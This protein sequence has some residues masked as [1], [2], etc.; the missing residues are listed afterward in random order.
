MFP[1]ARALFPLSSTTHLCA[2]GDRAATTIRLMAAVA[3]LGLTS[4]LT[5]Y[6]AAQSDAA[7]TPAASV[8]PLIGTGKGPGGGINLFPGPSLPFGMVQL[9]PDTEDNGY[10]YHYDQLTIHGFSMT[11]MS[12]PG[13]SNEGDVFFTATTGPVKTQVSDFQSP[14]SHSDEAASPGYYRVRLARW[15][16]NAELSA[17]DRTGIARFT[18][19]A[20]KPANILVPI[21]HTLNHTMAAEVR[22]VGDRQI[23]GYVE[24]QAFCG[25]KQTYKVYFD[26][27]FS[28][29]FGSYGTWSGAPY[30]GPGTVTASS[31]AAKQ[32]THNAWIG[33]YASWPAAQHTQT[34]TARVGISYVDLAGAENNLKA[35]SGGK[36]FSTIRHNAEGAWNKALRVIDVS[37]G[38]AEERTVFY[39]AL[40]HSLMMPSIFSDAD[41][42]YIGFDNQIHQVAQGH[43]VYA[44]FSGWDIYRSQM[45]LVAMIEPQRMGDIAESVVLMYQQGG[46]VGRWPQINRYTN[47]M[48]GSP[49]SV[50]LATAW[51]DGIHG[52]DMDA[53]WKGMLLDA[54]QA[55]PAGKPYQ[56]QEG[57]DWI[58][59]IHYVPND[60]IKYGSVSQIQEDAIAYASLYYLAKDLGKA[61]EA[62]TLYQRALYYRNVF[63]HQDRFFRP[64]NADGQWVANFDPSQE[65]QQNHGFI[66]GSGWHYQWLAPSDLAWLVNAVGKDEF[67]QRLTQFFNYE[68]PGWYPQYY[69]PYNET[70]L[71]AP[72]EFNFSGQPWESQRVV[73]RVLKENYTDDPNGIPGND[74]C[75]A[76]SSWAV[77]SMMGLYSVDPASQAYEL[78]S[79]L[80][81]KVVVHLHEPYSG[82]AFTIDT[83]S[84]PE[85]NPY[86][87]SV[88]LNGNGHGRNWIS[89]RDIAAGGTLHFTLGASANHSWGAA[90]K[91][92]PPSLSQS[93]P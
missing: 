88:Q 67:N 29:P 80:F 8:N 49:L 76:M 90:A 10:G 4:L 84:D 9:S 31:R 46:W 56:G 83:S 89:F 72:F 7:V 59:K 55:P 73:R 64:R 20:G 92:A 30:G 65:N 14:Y 43:A 41:G 32:E 81:S 35:E 11:H 70:D 1:S 3:V 93:K 45:P 36:D 21:S 25:N 61:D 27:T 63:N 5:C 38:T 39:T 68:K 53:G 57:I 51:L 87:Q 26:M 2:R 22:I 91:D 82:K 78:V 47:V 62:K 66:E 86:I 34:V 15:D 13:C 24:N 37:G 33:A 75:G 17:T 54:T 23:E 52:F 19:P 40:Y 74:D 79:P 60:K 16:I 71:E 69:N 6:A 48:A 85:A 42:R 18:F 77:L 50:V 44:N 28:R 12:G 58:N